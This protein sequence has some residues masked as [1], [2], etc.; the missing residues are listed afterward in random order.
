MK[1]F[2]RLV[3]YFFRYKW[4]II[5][6]LI[7]VAFMSLAD[8]GTAFVTA[9]LLGVLQSIG[10]LVR[11]G[12]AIVVE[13]PIDILGFFSDTITIR[14]YE[15][16]F[17]L[18]IMATLLFTALIVVKVVFVYVREYLMSSVQQKILLRFR[19]DLFDTIVMMPIRYF[20]QNKTGQIMSR[21]TNDVNQLEQSLFLTVEI[22]QN[23]VYTLV[24][25]TALVLTNW[26][27]T[28]FSVVVFLLSG[29]IS[30]R[31]GDRIRAISRDLTNS[32]AD[33]S[34]FLQ[35]KISAVRIVKSFN[36][37]E[38]EKKDFR[39]KAD[40]SYHF[41]MKIVRIWALL[42]P[43]NELFNAVVMALLVVFTAYLFIQGLMTIETMIRFLIILTF[44][45]KPLKALA[46]GVARIQRTL[47][48]AGLIF[49]MLDM[50]PEKIEPSQKAAA[51]VR[52]E[53]E[54]QNVTFT[55]N[56][57][58]EAL[59]AI[60]FKAEAG[61]KVALVGRS[62]SGK[63]TFINLIP[64]FYELTT[65]R[66]LID[67]VD[68][69]TMGLSALRSHIA[70]VPQ[71]VTLFAGTI[72]DNI[73]YG[74]LEATEAEIVEAARIANA[75]GFI[76]KLEHGY[77]TEVGERGL[78]LSGGQRQRIAIARAALR[79]PAILLLDE[80]TS[81][82]DT[83][84]EKMVQEALDR[85]MQGRTSFVIAHRLSTV[86]R[87][88]R[89]I[90]LDNGTIVEV[91]THEQLVRNDKGLYKHLYSLQFLESLEMPETRA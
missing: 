55:Y 82:L 88:D 9:K 52:G 68:V 46:E 86:F 81:A 60:D 66:I 21:I 34:A 10:E 13:I 79:N 20:D 57:E 62:G 22:I 16:S 90:V 69:G 65:G 38:H 28:I 24:F 42:S 43:I 15:E 63:T 7:S 47:V 39:S 5:G 76:E 91:G 3:K 71:E 51:P 54:F 32:V 73:R 40:T 4:R 36:R 37:E 75:H 56:G 59:K 41:S 80:A 8:T 45:A 72:Y 49:D 31:F 83:E 25:A 87:C 85:L 89:I 26:Q 84:S 11:K 77:T 14:G 35:E 1:V 74:R 61:E 12:S 64:R 44:L 18:T 70:I 48:S 33:I 50:Q 23:I 6:G 67:G 19:V 17:R 30:R 53:V 78:Q 29:M 2:L 27:L 58:T